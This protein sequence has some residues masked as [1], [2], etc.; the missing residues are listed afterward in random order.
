MALKNKEFLVAGI[1]NLIKTNNYQIDWDL[2]DLE[3]EVDSKL[4]FSENWQHIKS[5]Y[6]LYSLR[7][8]KENVESV[9]C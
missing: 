6:H 1:K 7:E 4:S 9:K 5:K 2:I 3:A 8:L